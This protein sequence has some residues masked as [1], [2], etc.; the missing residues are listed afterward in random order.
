MCSSTTTSTFISPNICR[1]CHSFGFYTDLSAEFN[2]LEGNQTYEEVLKQTFNIQVHSLN[3]KNT[4]FLCLIS[5]LRLKKI[6]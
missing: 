1:C 5:H 2:P 3:S 4:L 6:K